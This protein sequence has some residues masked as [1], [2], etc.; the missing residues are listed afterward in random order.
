MR[1]PDVNSV[2]SA[3][4][5]DEVDVLGSSTARSLLRRNRL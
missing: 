3:A 4:E 1:L 5:V 2:S